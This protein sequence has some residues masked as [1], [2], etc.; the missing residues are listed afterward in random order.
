MIIG[1]PL[2][3]AFH[4][5]IRRRVKLLHTL[6]GY[7]DLSVDRMRGVPFLS[8]E[9]AKRVVAKA[10][11]KTTTDFR[12]WKRPLNVPS[13]PQKVYEQWAGWG[14]FL[15]TG[16]TRY[17]KFLSYAKAKA[18]MQQHTNIRTGTEFDKWKERP[19]FIPCNPETKYVRKGWES[20][21]AFLGENYGRP[22]WDFLPYE[23]ARALTIKHGIKSRQGFLRWENKPSK[24][25]AAPDHHYE[26]VGVWKGWG[27]FLGTGN[28]R[29]K[30]F[31]SFKKARAFVRKMGLKS[32]AA[33]H[34]IRPENLPRHPASV[35]GG[36]GWRG[37]QHFFGLE[38][39]EAVRQA[40]REAGKL[41]WERKRALY[42]DPFLPYEE[43]RIVVRKLGVKNR[44]SYKRK[45]TENL[46]C[47]PDVIYR[48]KGWQSWPHFLGLSEL[49]MRLI[50][51]GAARR[52]WKTLRRFPAN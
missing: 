35:Y 11:V 19:N 14:E 51:S 41:A 46:P 40:R 33:Y 4:S 30:E 32:L 38:D 8:Y 18:Y 3:K 49:D 31:L 6:P 39:R 42:G 36:K 22:N 5:E 43:A 28:L 26:T 17:K 1:R 15:G 20:W 9:E 7:A 24:M 45:R 25:P 2:S 29:S 13:N 16:N 21:E 27:E 52:G 23:E 12:K 50:R 48:S 34:R 47:N 44:E 10:G 37:S